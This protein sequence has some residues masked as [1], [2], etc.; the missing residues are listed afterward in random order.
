M[1]VYELKYGARELEKL[2]VKVRK[3]AGLAFYSA[4]IRG[5]SVI[6]TQIIPARI[7]QPVDRGTYRAGWRAVPYMVG[8]DV[9][10]GDIYNAEFWS[11]F[12]EKGVR[13]ANVKIGG[14]LLRA[15]AEWATRKGIVDGDE[16]PKQVA[17]AIA[18]SMQKKGIFKG[19]EGL[20]ILGELMQKHMPKILR[21]ELK[22]QAASGGK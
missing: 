5:V 8:E 15:L 18:K 9:M 21:E 11:M 10:G 20:N 22:R 1:S 6:Q 12:I 16:D 19:G 3:A 7:P 17:W 14:A 2:G 4:A 13:A